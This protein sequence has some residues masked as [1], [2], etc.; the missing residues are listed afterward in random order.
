MR[1]PLFLSN[2]TVEELVNISEGIQAYIGI[3]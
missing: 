3:G 2:G 1:L